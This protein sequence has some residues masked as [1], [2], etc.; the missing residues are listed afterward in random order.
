MYLKFTTNETHLFISGKTFHIKETLKNIKAIWNPEL[1]SWSVPIA[2]DTSFLRTSL[3]DRVKEIVLVNGN[4]VLSAAEK[5]EAAAEKK[6]LREYAASSEG[7]KATLLA[8]LAEKEK[9]N[10][11]YHWICCDQC[12]V[13]DWVR[14]HTSC[15]VHA[16]D[17]GLYK[18]TFRVRGMIYTGD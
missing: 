18:N 15:N 2:L 3:E 14:Q 10:G 4:P 16:E 6:R 5:K 8:V 17:C 1:K 13:I 12:E 11:A 7:K 9:G